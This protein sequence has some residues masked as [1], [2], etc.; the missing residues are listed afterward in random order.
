MN[1]KLLIV[2][3]EPANL[4]I[5]ERL[6]RREYEVLTASSGDEGLEL[7]SLH[8]IALII[9]DQ[10]MP[11]M[12]G[13]DFLKRAAEM[14]RQTV[15]IILTGYTDAG[16]LVEAI[17][18]GVVYKY[19]TKPWVNE[20]LQQTVKR[21]LQHY[22]TIKIQH[23]FSLE[24]S[25]LQAQLKATLDSF[26]RAMGEMVDLKDP[27]A[28]A[29]TLRVIECATAIGEKLNLDAS[30]IKQLSLAASLHEVVHIGIPNH[31]LFKETDLTHEELWTVMQNLERGLKLLASVPDLKEIASI[32]LYQ[33]ENWDGSGYPDGLTGERIPLHARIIHVADAFDEMTSPRSLQPGLAHNEAVER[34]RAQAGRKF[35]PE[36]IEAFGGLKSTTHTRSMENIGSIGLSQESNPHLQ[37]VDNNLTELL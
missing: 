18:S 4:R 14:R 3:D 15:R 24:N 2:D 16:A 5:M 21:A 31:I 1:Y 17:N 8:D 36:I 33:H 25:R 12:T 29:H 10:R 27:S 26:V 34:L 7:L 28:R 30:E 22:E 32:V 6:F 19:V 23:H 20:D 35:D 13:I 11:G 37:N 9:S